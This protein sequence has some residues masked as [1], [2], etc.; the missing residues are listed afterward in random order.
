MR[1][2]RSV[3]ENQ[4]VENELEDPSALWIYNLN[5][6]QSFIAK[7]ACTHTYFFG[8]LN[9]PCIFKCSSK[10]HKKLTI[11]IKNELHIYK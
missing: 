8:T 11:N 4:L 9:C 5:Q 2:M 1:E 3:M 6:N 7:C 10:T